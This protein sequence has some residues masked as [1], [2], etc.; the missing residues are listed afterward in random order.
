MKVSA[1]RRFAKTR[2]AD[3]AAS[4][5][6]EI[7]ELA[8]IAADELQRATA[9]ELRRS[10]AAAVEERPPTRDELD[11]SAAVS[12]GLARSGVPM[13]AANRWRRLMVRRV[14]EE[15]AAGGVEYLYRLWDWADA[16]AAGTAGV[17]RQLELDVEARDDDQRA[18]F[19]RG[20]LDG[21]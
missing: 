2:E 19:V 10:H 18:R 12:A 21:S 9:S 1:G 3:I 4:L 8:Q 16:V 15:D 13:E 7:P 11:A 14:F 20:L 6:Q 17:Y 5:R